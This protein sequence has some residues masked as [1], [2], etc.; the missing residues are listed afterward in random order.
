[1]LSQYRRRAS[2]SPH[3]HSSIL[4][5]YE[6]S[7]KPSVNRWH[8]VHGST[9][10]YTILRTSGITLSFATAFLLHRRSFTSIHSLILRL[11]EPSV[12]RWHCVYVST[13]NYTVLWTV[14]HRARVCPSFATAFL[15]YHR[16]QRSSSRFLLPSHESLHEPGSR[17]LSSFHEYRLS[18]HTAIDT[19]RWDY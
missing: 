18:I 9:I 12:N 5:F 19:I 15:F 1:M 16:S 10:D 8:C 2:S 14:M 17:I 11:C 6:R 13:I 7:I 3:E 4:R